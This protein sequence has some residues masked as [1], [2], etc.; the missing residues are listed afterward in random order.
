LK[1]SPL[2]REYQLM[3]SVS[4]KIEPVI[5]GLPP[6]PAFTNMMDTALFHIGISLKILPVYSIILSLSCMKIKQEFYG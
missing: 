4:Y 2:E 1:I 3:F 5:S 6:G